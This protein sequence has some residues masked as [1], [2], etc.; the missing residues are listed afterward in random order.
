MQLAC[1]LTV[2][3]EFNQL[4]SLFFDL[5]SYSKQ[6]WA[7]DKSRRNSAEIIFG[8]T[9]IQTRGRWVHKRKLHLCATLPPSYLNYLFYQYGLPLA[10]IGWVQYT[11]KCFALSTLSQNKLS[12]FARKKHSLADIQ[13][14]GLRGRFFGKL[15]SGIA[16]TDLKS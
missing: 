6:C 14:R 2:L 5:S 11:I 10:I 3:Y 15:I 12:N 8:K 4:S 7:I 13:T 16:K 1:H 9:E